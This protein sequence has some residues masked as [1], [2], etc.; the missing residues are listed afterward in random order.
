MSKKIFDN[1]LIIGMGLIGSSVA[2]SLK[3]SKLSANILGYDINQNVINK[4]KK[5]KIVDLFVSNL[6]NSK[7][8]F[9]LII[10][11][12]PLGTYSSIFKKLNKLI[13]QDCIITDV[14]SVK[15]EVINQYEKHCNNSYITFV[16]GHPIAGLEKSGPEYG[17]ADLFKNRYCIITTKNSKNKNVKKIEKMWKSFGMKVEYM[18]SK[19]H[20]KVLAMTSHIP[21]LIAYSIVATTTDLENRMK[22]EVI[23]YSAAG[24]RDFTR[25]AGSD[26]IMWR[27]VYSQ[28][29]EAV[30]DMLG[31]FSED[32][33]SL[34][35]AIRNKDLNKMEKIF[36]STKK[37][38]K[39]IEDYGQ[40]GSFDPREKK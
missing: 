34:Q 29:K 14:G 3:K 40:A 7:Y 26:P 15:T 27:D 6:N 5:L 20:D 4:C 10:I 1:T 22:D 18:N 25:L 37:I 16:P 19:H 12:S 28:N 31:R 38:R 33:A 30:L 11:C 9:D 39:L 17:F 35:K 2:R 21:Q 32:L 36:S 24:F 8:Q 13:K 23:K